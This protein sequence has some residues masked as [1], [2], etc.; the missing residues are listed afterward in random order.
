MKIALVHNFYRSI[1]PSGEDIVV[2]QEQRL[3][4]SRGNE[5][6]GY[7]ARSDDLQGRAIATIGAALGL[8]FRPDV[9]LKLAAFLSRERPD[10]VH[11][12]NTFPLL[13]PAVFWACSQAGIPIVHTLHN[14]RWV[15]PAGTFMRHGRVCEECVDSG[16]QR[17]VLRGCYRES[18]AQTAPIAAMLGLN[19]LLGTLQT[20]VTR[21]IALTQFA[22][23]KLIEGGLPAERIRVKPNFLADPPVAKLEEDDGRVAFVGRL[24]SEKGLGVLMDAW[25][26]LPDVP[27]RIIGSGPMEPAVRQWAAGRANVEITGILAWDDAL[28]AILDARLL[29]MPSLWYEGFPL[30]LREALACGT[31]AIASELGSMAEIIQ[32]GRTGLLVPPGDAAAL[33][34]A[35]REA[36]FDD[37]L[38]H[39]LGVAARADFE[40]KY[41]ADVNYAQLMRI[42][43][44]AIADA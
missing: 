31:P 5:V 21:F 4:E 10:V 36:F 23:R 34:R 1:S 44:E 37:A 33:A 12:H 43:E 42:Y 41:T 26:A 3:L 22:R 32:H 20:K 8:G 38:L 2:V 35:V 30:T 24:S 18:R 7:F 19:R 6:V 27:L 13:S 16:L 25:D 39:R 11:V 14:Y 15:C 9:L 28:R 17:S 40:E 29:V